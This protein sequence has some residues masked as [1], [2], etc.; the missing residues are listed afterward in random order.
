MGN[1]PCLAT[2]VLDADMQSPGEEEEAK[3]AFEQ[4]VGKL[5]LGHQAAHL[6]GNAQIWKERFDAEH[7]ERGDKGDHQNADG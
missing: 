6:N 1:D 2:Q 7:A 4:G 3:H 5:D